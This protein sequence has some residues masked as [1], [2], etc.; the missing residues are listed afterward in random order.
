MSS[1]K[2]VVV[3]FTRPQIEIVRKLLA[4]EVATYKNW[5]ATAVE[6]EE[7]ERAKTLVADMRDRANIFADV[8][9]VIRVA[10]EGE[11]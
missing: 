6:C 10:D 5:I 2:P 4:D 1:R 7:F 8:N 3:S 11:H 9:R